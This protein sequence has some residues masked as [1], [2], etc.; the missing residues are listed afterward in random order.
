MRIKY[1]V[2]GEHPLEA[3]NSSTDTRGFYY[4]LL[5]LSEGRFFPLRASKWN[6]TT[7]ILKH[8]VLQRST[9]GRIKND[10]NIICC[11]NKDV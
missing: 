8:S 4:S 9:N 2:S 6:L 5:F 7:K 1:I 3:I 10:L 11:E